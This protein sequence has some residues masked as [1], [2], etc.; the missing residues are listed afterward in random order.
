MRRPLDHASL[1]QLFLSARSYNQ[2]L[3]QEVEDDQV[4][5]IYEIIK[6]GPTSAN[7]CPARFVWVRSPEGKQKL[8][9][10]VW[11]YNAPKI[12]KAP[13]T[14]IVGYD[15]AFSD[16]LPQLYPS[17]AEIY[18]KLFLGDPKFNQLSAFR[19]SSLQGAYLIVA[20]RA[21]GLDCGPME[22]FDSGAV[23]EAF[24]PGTN[25]KTNFICSI[26]IGNN[27]SLLPRNPRLAFEQANSF[28]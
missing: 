11:E 23:D 24:F 22:G 25:I 15:L 17:R 13:L 18:R 5:Q 10:C 20:A 26:G 1:K 28:A 9:N 27:E 21:L 3:G 14:L 16:L 19:N 2:W 8:A 7:G 12:L 4:R 6:F